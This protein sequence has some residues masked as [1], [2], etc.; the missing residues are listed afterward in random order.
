MVR[1]EIGDF[2]KTK[3]HYFRSAQNS[4]LTLGQWKRFKERQCFAENL[5]LQ[6]V[7]AAEKFLKTCYKW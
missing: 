7:Q 3:N 1:S 5:G 4:L 6:F 2:R